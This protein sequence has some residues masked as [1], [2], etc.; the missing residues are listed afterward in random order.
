[1]RVGTLR[2]MWIRSMAEAAGPVWPCEGVCAV[3]MCRCSTSCSVRQR[4]L[5]VGSGQGH[6]ATCEHCLHLLVPAS[7]VVETVLRAPQR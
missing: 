6:A 2:C 3:F 5:G 1:M 4:G 7:V